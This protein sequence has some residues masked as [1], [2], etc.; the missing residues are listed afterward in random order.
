MPWDL[1]SSFILIFAA[2]CSDVTLNV[3]RKLMIVRGKSLLAATVGF[4][5]IMI[6]IIV[7]GSLLGGGKSLD[8]LEIIAYCSGFAT[9]NL[10]GIYLE[11]KLL[12]AIV[13]VTVIAGNDY[14]SL[15]KINE[16]RQAGFG[17]TVMIG[18]GKTGERVIGKI[19]CS[20]NHID[21]IREILG[22]QWFTFVSDIRSVRGGH[23]SSSVEK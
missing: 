1:L 23:F 2:R 22:E 16:L 4:F 9:G 21:K 15:D 12:D 8:L 7:L 3:F 13:L 6:Y 19:V 5:E 11:S 10:L 20:R 17:T 18:R 14:M